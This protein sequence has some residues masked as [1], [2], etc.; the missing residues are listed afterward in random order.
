MRKFLPLTWPVALALLL[1]ACK[2]GN[3]DAQITKLETAYAAAPSTAKADSLILLYQAAEKAHPNEHGVNLRYLTKAADLQ[4]FRKNDGLSAVRTL[5]EALNKHAEGQNLVEPIA[6][7]TRIWTG[8]AYKL[9]STVRIQMEDVNKL[10]AQMTKHMAWIDSSLVQLEREMSAA[11]AAAPAD[12]EKARKFIEIAEGYGILIQADDPGKY[13][14]LMIKAGN[15]A[16][17]IENYNKAVQLYFGVGEK[18]KDHPK[19]PTALFLMAFTYANDLHDLEKAKEAYEEFLKRYPNDEMAESARGEL[20]NL[21]KS[22]E[23]IIK[24]MEKK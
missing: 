17:S 5:D 6:L 13:A 1:Y 4:Y 19:A 21:G 16:K 14:D 24:E 7:C 11:N 15:V 10:R 3:P 2:G 23:Q 9:P 20:K 18:M 8:C 12:K 22:P